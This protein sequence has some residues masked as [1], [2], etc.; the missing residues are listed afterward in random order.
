M[1][2]FDVGQPITHRGPAT[3][4]GGGRY[5]DDYNYR[6]NCAPARRRTPC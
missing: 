3:S 2:E 4:D 1:G 5:S 6:I